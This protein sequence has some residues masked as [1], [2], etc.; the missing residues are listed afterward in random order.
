MST[1]PGTNRPLS[2]RFAWWVV[3]V[4]GLWNVG[5]A[6]ALGR[7]VAWLSDLPLVPDP[8]L[9]MIMAL[10]WGALFL[11]AAV[12]LR[13]GRLWSRWLVPLLIAAYGVYEFGMIALYASDPPAL[14]SI[15]LYVALS[16]LVGWLF[17]H[18]VTEAY[19]ESRNMRR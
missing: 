14:L 1:P 8:R 6:V 12:A 17:W 16:V 18:P 3:V 13:R 9:R 15:L 4:L 2:I 10:I 19:Y 5:R 11:T 7:Q